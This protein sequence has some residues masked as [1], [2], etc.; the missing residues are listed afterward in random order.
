LKVEKLSAERYITPNEEIFLRSQCDLRPWFPIVE[1]E[2]YGYNCKCYHV[3]MMCRNILPPGCCAGMTYCYNDSRSLLF[4]SRS[5]SRSL[6]ASMILKANFLHLLLLD[7][8]RRMQQ[9]E[10]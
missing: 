6:L 10:K 7:R 4:V 9:P 3:T 5:G 8:K 2:G 1:L